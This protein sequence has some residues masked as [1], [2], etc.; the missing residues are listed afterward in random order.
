MSLIGTAAIAAS[1]LAGC[2]GERPSLTEAPFDVSAATAG[3]VMNVG[4]RA[5]VKVTAKVKPSAGQT[6]VI[7]T[8]PEGTLGM[9]IAG[10]V[11]DPATGVTYWRL[12]FDSG[13]DGWVRRSQLEPVAA[14]SSR[15]ALGQRVQAAPEGANIRGGAS[16]ASALLGSQPSGAMGT[17]TGG[18]A[19]DAAGDGLIRWE[20]DFDSGADGWAAEDYLTDPVAV[21]VVR[22]GWYAAPGGLATNDGTAARPWNLATALAGA[23]GRVQ[24]GDTIW[25]RGGT[26]AGSFQSAVA[27]TA[28]APVVV[29]QYPG[30]RAIIDNRGSSSTALTVNGAWSQFR[31]F[32]IMNSDPVR[33]VSFT[34]NGGRTHALYNKANHTRYINLVVHDAGVAYYGEPANYDVEVAG[35]IFYNNGWQGPDRGHGHALYIKSDV[36][37]FIARD[38]IIFS[39]FGYGVHVYSNPGSGAMR[40]IRLENNVLFNN[41]TLSTNSASANMLVGGGDYATD[42]VVRGNLAYFSPSVSAANVR[43]GSGSVLNGAVTVADNYVAGGGPVMDVGYWSSASFTGNTLVGAGIVTSIN[44]SATAGKV[45]SGNTHYRDPLAA[46]WRYTGSSYAFNVWRTLT[47]FAA[48]D[49]ALAGTP[50]ATRVMVRPNPYQQGRATIVVFNWGGQGSA[51]VSLGGVLAAGDGYEVRNVQDLFGA[52]VASGSYTGSVTV[53]LTGVTPPVPVGLTSSRA[54]RTGPAFDVFIVTKR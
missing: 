32:E 10:P 4:G 24:P 53:P 31:D 15:F 13:T 29:R 54:P 37:P 7:G 40:N 14:V 8:Q 25:L 36:G 52:P 19:L 51:T 27:G 2:G 49:V 6:G 11:V 46:A 21:Q 18:A 42:D 30:E 3:T 12:N 5:R 45:W 41:G 34:G 48:G 50:T 33:T 35:C 1:A 16:L 9:V 20:I 17:V 47:T 39:Q 44:Q 26:Y 23:G 38:N 28:V 43:I 22:S